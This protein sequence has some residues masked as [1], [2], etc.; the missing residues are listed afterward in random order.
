MAKKLDYVKYLERAQETEQMIG[1]LEDIG[2]LISVISFA[3][4]VG[5]GAYL[6]TKYATKLWRK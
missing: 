3:A 1:S 6:F 5:R 2:A 4:I